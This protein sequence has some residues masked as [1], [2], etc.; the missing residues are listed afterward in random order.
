MGGDYWR[1]SIGP[2]Q[3]WPVSSF[4]LHHH[5]SRAEV[6]DED[7]DSGFAAAAAIRLYRPLMK[8]KGYLDSFIA[9]IQQSREDVSQ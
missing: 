7:G 8:S 1:G 3:V 4:I 6:T 2:T 9:V 5:S